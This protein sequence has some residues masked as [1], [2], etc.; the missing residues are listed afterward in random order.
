V[1]KR[2]YLLAGMLIIPWLTLPLLGRHTFKKYLP[3]AI[4]ICT[5]TKILDEI[6]RRKK[7]W[8]FYKGFQ[9]LNSMDFLNIGPYFVTSLWMLKFTYGKIVIYLIFNTILHVFFI[10]FLGLKYLKR[11]KI[12]ELNKLTKF[13]YLII[14]FI[15]ALLLYSFQWLVN[16]IK[17]ENPPKRLNG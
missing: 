10:Y 5:F 9:P 8:K 12:L 16:I 11:Y 14:D 6:G 2:T 13:Q 17:T 3:S 4:F 7:W 15:R 1:K